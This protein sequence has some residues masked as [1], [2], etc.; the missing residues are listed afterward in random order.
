MYTHAQKN[1]VNTPTL[2]MN[3]VHYVIV[4]VLSLNV[5]TITNERSE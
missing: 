4:N 5:D 3:H 1:H 2:V